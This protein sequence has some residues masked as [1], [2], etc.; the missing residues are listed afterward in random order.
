MSQYFYEYLND[1]RMSLVNISTFGV[2]RVIMLLLTMILLILN[3]FGNDVNFIGV[4][5]LVLYL[6]AIFYYK[7]IEYAN[8]LLFF[9]ILVPMLIGG[10]L[11]ERG[12]YLFEI[13]KY[14][15]WNGTFLVNLF[16]S[17]VFIEF[18]IYPIKSTNQKNIFK[19][20]RLFI[21]GLIVLAILVLYGTF[22]KT[23][24]PIFSGVHRTVYFG[25]IVPDYVN[26]IKG[27]LSFACLVLG[28]YYFRFKSKRYIAYYVLIIAYH[29]LCAIKGGELLIILYTFYLPITL[30]Y[31]STL[32]GDK[33]KALYRKIRTALC[34]LISGVFFII[35]INYQT[36][37]NYDSGTTALEKIEKRVEAAGQIWWVINDENQVQNTIRW[38]KFIRNFEEGNNILDKGMNQLMTEVV[39]AD[40]LNVWRAPDARGRSLANG[41][42]AIGFY[43][44]GY[45]GVVA[46]LIIIG[47]IIILI[48]QSILASF[49]SGDVL[50]FL[51]IGPILELIIRVVAQGDI[52][53]LFEKR[54]YVIVI[55]Y[56]IYGV[57]KSLMIRPKI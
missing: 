40:I 8:N 28:Y 47:V 57:V 55:A 31:T 24:I 37:E 13:D 42:P 34:L 54:A 45:A 41:F 49:R 14:T 50:A 29:I 12:V 6:L 23:G 36:V 32:M 16:F 46:F 20:N 33:K 52:N 48:K 38:D 9:I 56:I 1:K 22:L 2:A 11:I 18:L 21:E 27:R 30:Y 35:F 10:A 15:Y 51:F 43:Y 26:L 3:Y 25:S 5:V 17:M 19:V 7:P 53:I 4:I 44:F 39:P